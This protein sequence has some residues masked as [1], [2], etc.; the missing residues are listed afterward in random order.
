MKII[1][2]DSGDIYNHIIESYELNNKES[3]FLEDYG[4][5]IKNLHDDD[6]DDYEIHIRIIDNNTYSFRL[7]DVVLDYNY[8]SDDDGFL[9]DYEEF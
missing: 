6:D 3:E 4:Y 1:H 5:V 8:D 7:V 9:D 2:I